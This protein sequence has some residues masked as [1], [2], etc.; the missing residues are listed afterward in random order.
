VWKWLIAPWMAVV[1]AAA[2]LWAKDL[3]NFPDPA[4]ARIIFWHV[5]MAWLCLVWIWIGAYY[6][7]RFLFSRNAGNLDF[8]RR[9]ALANEVGL[10]CTAL[11]TVT[12]MVF[13]YRQWNTAWN[14][15]PKQ[16]AITA[17]ILIYLAYFGLRMS[18]DDP[19]SRGRLAAAYSVFGAI[20]APVLF[21]VA[22]YLPIVETLH[23]KTNIITGGL[24]STWRTIY[25]ASWA[26]FTG[27]TI[28]M[29]QLKLRAAVVF[30][31]I[32]ARAAGF[33]AETELPRTEPERRPRKVDDEDSRTL[34]AVGERDA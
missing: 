23:P 28:W 13:A 9:S 21:F 2:F 25:L 3:Q 17:V 8:D 5:P 24:D 31:R 26:G 22:P 6:G 12:G 4:T 18:I 27:I 34:T 15:D 20:S 11:A 10:L 1:T 7:V 19:Q 16:V 14:W 32:D 29:F 33:V 30:E